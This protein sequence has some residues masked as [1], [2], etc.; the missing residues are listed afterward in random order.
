MDFVFI[1]G[2]QHKADYLAKWLGRPVTHVKYDLDELQS[3]D[4][5]EV[6]EH[7]ARQAYEVA[8]KPV[9]IEDVALTIHAL[10][11]LPGTLIKWFLQ[12]LGPE[13]I[14]KILENFDDRAATAAIVY[15]LYDG[16]QM[17][18]FN[19][20]TNGQIA[21]KPRSSEN[22]GWHGALSWNSIFVPEGMAKTYAEMTDEELLPVSHRAKAIAKLRGFLKDF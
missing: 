6:A 19:G 17:H 21:D 15:A 1:T 7:K 3:L 13:G 18:V 16:T 14:V 11:Q 5:R 10:G 20:E 22:D 12:E 9:L 8:G 2:N 4:L